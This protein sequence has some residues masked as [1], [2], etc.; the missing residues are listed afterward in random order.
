MDKRSNKVIKHLRGQRKLID[1]LRIGLQRYDLL[2]EVP[3][4]EIVV[5]L[6]ELA[7]LENA[8]KSLQVSAYDPQA[9]Q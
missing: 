2:N 1:L 6:N 4:K 5:C 9:Y 3:A 7:R 8:L